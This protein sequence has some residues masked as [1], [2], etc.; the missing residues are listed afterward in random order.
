MKRNAS[1]NVC[2]FAVSATIIDRPRP[3]DG[4]AANG[5]EQ[6]VGAERERDRE[7]RPRE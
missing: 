2:R 5:D 7:Q 6:Q 1:T 3:R 4:G